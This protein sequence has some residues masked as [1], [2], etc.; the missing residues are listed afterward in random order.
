MTSL[1]DPLIGSQVDLA[2]VIVWIIWDQRLHKHD[3]ETIVTQVMAASTTVPATAI[4]TPIAP[5]TVQESATHMPQA[6]TVLTDASQLLAAPHSVEGLTT[7][8]QVTVAPIT[9][10]ETATRTLNAPSTQ[11]PNVNQTSTSIRYCSTYSHHSLITAHITTVQVPA[12]PPTAVSTA[13]TNVP[14]VQPSAAPITEGPTSKQAESCHSSDKVSKD[15]IVHK[16][17]SSSHGKLPIL[18]TDDDDDDDS[19]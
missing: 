14:T 17:S 3:K 7:V 19:R 11:Q 5:L 1:P 16:I 6:T 13:S 10:P 18:I 2:S 8:T 12:A 15:P 4:Q 9:V